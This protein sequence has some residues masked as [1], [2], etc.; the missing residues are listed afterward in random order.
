MQRNTVPLIASMKAD[1]K[2]KENTATRG[3][4]RKSITLG[5]RA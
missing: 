2:A 1:L 3:T 5:L 4:S